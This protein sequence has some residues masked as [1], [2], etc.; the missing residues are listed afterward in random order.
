MKEALFY[1]TKGDKTV[2]CRLCNHFCHIKD[3]GRGLC[4]VRENQDGKLISLVYGRLVSANLDPIEK[5]PLAE[6]LY[7]EYPS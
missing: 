5:K 2:L 4:G 6:A 1:E 3:G 7:G